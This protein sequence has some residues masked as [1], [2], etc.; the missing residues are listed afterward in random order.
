MKDSGERINEL[1]TDFKEITEQLFKRIEGINTE[2]NE[3]LGHSSDLF[4]RDAI[5][6]KNNYQELAE[7]MKKYASNM[8]DTANAI[9]R[10][11]L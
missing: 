6:N 5:T 10:R 3:W 4:V 11:M 2:S 8:I 1:V 9:E 7:E